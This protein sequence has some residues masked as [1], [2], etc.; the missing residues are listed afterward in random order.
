MPNNW[1]PGTVSHTAPCVCVR[2]HRQL[3][4]ANS[5]AQGSRSGEPF[6][7]AVRRSQSLFPEAGSSLA[8]GRGGNTW[9]LL[10]Q[11]LAAAL[12][13][14]DVIYHH[15]RMKRVCAASLL[16][17]LEAALMCSEPPPPLLTA[18][19]SFL[20]FFPPFFPACLWFFAFGAAEPVSRWSGT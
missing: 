12:S 13:S 15:R 18:F 10:R 16:L 14:S 20:F 5:S 2:L 11:G 4:G 8:A 7:G 6:R 17:Q 1:P 19:L 3:T 9:S